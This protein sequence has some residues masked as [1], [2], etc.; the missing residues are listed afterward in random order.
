MNILL[1]GD[2][3]GTR[4]CDFL[5]S[6]LPGFKKLKA[7]DVVIAN[8][9]NAAPGNGITSSAA[10]HI[11]SSGVDFITTGNHAFRRSEVYHF[12]DER[13]DIIRPANVGPACPGKAR[14]CSGS[15]HATSGRRRRSGS[16]CGSGYQPTG[17]PRGKVRH[18]N[19]DHHCRRAAQA[20]VAVAKAVV[21]LLDLAPINIAGLLHSLDLGQLWVGLHHG[22]DGL[23]DALLID[24]FNVDLDALGGTDGQFTLGLQLALDQGFIGVAF[25]FGTLPDPAIFA[26]T[27]S[28][29]FM[30]ATLTAMTYPIFSTNYYKE[31]RTIFLQFLSYTFLPTEDSTCS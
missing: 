19:G 16:G 10:E 20:G 17:R 31:T 30:Y 26:I 13:G 5:R 4:G 15:P 28:N 12:L 29:V 21:Q 27:L 2:I 3:V 11:F 1:I 9:E 6:V 24:L 23:T 25:A 18:R 22:V 14:T 8:G 7:I